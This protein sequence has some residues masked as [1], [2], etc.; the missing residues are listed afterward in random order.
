MSGYDRQAQV[1]AWDVD[2]AHQRMAGLASWAAF[3]ARWRARQGLPLL[4]PMDVQYLT[5]GD[6]CNGKGRPLPPEVARRRFREYV[7]AAIECGVA[8]RVPVAGRRQAGLV[9]AEL[10]FVR[11]SGFVRWLG[12]HPPDFVYGRRDQG[13]Y[14]AGSLLPQRPYGVPVASSQR[15]AQGAYWLDGTQ[16]GDDDDGD[17]SWIVAWPGSEGW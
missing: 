14:A 5:P 15:A 4:H 1:R 7:A 17:D 11:A 12:K 9:S 3:S 10:G 8:S 16:V 6:F 2:S 13:A